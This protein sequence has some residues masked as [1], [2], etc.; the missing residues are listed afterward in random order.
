MFCLLLFA[1][2]SKF[3]WSFACLNCSENVQSFV[4]YSLKPPCKSPLSEN[5]NIVK[6][7]SGGDILEFS[8]ISHMTDWQSGIHREQ[9]SIKS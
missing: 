6:N 8:N 3:L 5:P 4:T 2:N 7:S 9:S 1:T